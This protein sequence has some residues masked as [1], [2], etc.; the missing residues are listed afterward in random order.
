MDVA[1]LVPLVFVLIGCA[2][3]VAVASGLLGLFRGG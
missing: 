3:V 1:D 2:A